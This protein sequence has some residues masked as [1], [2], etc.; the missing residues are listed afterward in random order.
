MRVTEKKE[1]KKSK[2]IFEG[3][4]TKHFQELGKDVNPGMKGLTKYKMT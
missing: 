4:K 1:K 2:G 3:M